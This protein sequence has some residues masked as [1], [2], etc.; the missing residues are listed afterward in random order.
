MNRLN[1]STSRLRALFLLAMLLFVWLFKPV[2]MIVEHHDVKQF[3]TIHTE[4]DVIS[5]DHHFDCEICEF[6][7]CTFL[8]QDFIV[9][10]S[11]DFQLLQIS[12]IQSEVQSVP[13]VVF[14]PGLRAP[15][16]V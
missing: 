2:H 16:V 6:E 14:S 11:V 8:T 4:K 5:A 7:F 1:T 13:I 12:T 15:P 10:P 9:Y 3:I